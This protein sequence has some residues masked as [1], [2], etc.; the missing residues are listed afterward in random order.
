LL[1]DYYRFALCPDRVLFTH[2]KRFLRDRIESKA[3]WSTTHRDGAIAGW[4]AALE[5]LRQHLPAATKSRPSASF[6]LSNH[7][8]HYALFRKNEELTGQ[9]ELLAYARHRMKA[10]FGE[11][12]PDRVLKLTNVGAGGG[13]VASAVDGTLLEEIRTLCREKNLRLVSIRPYLAV[14]F[15]RCRNALERRS[16]WFIVHEDGRVIAALFK[17]GNW[18]SLASRRVGREW[19]AELPTVL[20]REQ[21]LAE[22]DGAECSEV[23]L[24]APGLSHVGDFPGSRY[25]VELLRPETP[26]ILKEG[27][28]AMAA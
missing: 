3:S 25:Q 4:R 17:D 26:G 24:Y 10:V 1:R 16:T 18:I 23:L 20:D 2:R 7:F 11:T 28:Y 9:S 8:C 14:A 22:V 6:V 5:A 15:N 27:D 13:Y 19:K 12:A 21:L